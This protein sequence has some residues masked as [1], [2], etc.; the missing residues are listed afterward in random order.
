MRYWCTEANLGY[1]QAQRWD[2]RPGGEAD[3]SSLVI[4]ALKEAGFDTGGATYTGNMRS[5][6]TAR[7]WA[8]VA[9]RPTSA[10]N[11][12]AGDILLNDA[13]HVALYLGGGQLAQ[14]SIDE[15]GRVAGGRSGDQ[16]D[17]ET[18]VAPF[19][20]YRHGGWS[21]VLRYVGGQTAASAT[22]TIAG[23]SQPYNPN[24]YGAAYVKDLQSR[25]VS[26]GYS[27]GSSGADGV[28]GADTFNAVKAYQIA[29]G[30][31][32]DGIPGPD[33][34]GALKAGKGKKAAAKPATD[35]L[36]D[37][38]WGPATTKALQK[39]LGTPQDGVISSQDQ[40]RK[41]NVPAAGAGWEWV[42]NPQGSQAIV[43]LQKRL[44]VGADGIIGP[45]T[46]RRL[47]DHLGVPVDGYAG[48]QTVKTLQAKL[49]RG[50]L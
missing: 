26:L 25:L 32:V 40:G 17:H 24:G 4:H 45:G 2:I 23:S 18:N 29:V 39:I 12:R 5:A 16:T 13:N 19:Y 30:L 1:D 42:A 7:G 34:L 33:T 31:T 44:G 46:I 11:L 50:A 20:V 21:A 22:P 8:V 9:V 10:A 6:L 37:G 38:V 36:S 27:V 41:V 35:A 28:L 43:A 3:C 49:S 14:A 47:Q 15:R 48:A